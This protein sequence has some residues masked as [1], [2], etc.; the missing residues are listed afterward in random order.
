MSYLTEGQSMENP[1]KKSE[2]HIEKYKEILKKRLTL[3]RIKKLLE[4]SKAQRKAS[5][6]EPPKK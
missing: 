5:Q 6:P 4:E 1:P 2:Q 3:Q